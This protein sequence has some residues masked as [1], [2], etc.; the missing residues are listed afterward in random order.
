MAARNRPRALPKEDVDAHEEKDLWTRICSG[1]KELAAMSKRTQEIESELAHE[2]ER[3]GDGS[4]RVAPA[5]LPLV[6]PTR[7]LPI[8][9][10]SLFVVL[11]MFMNY[12]LFYV[13]VCY[14][15]LSLTRYLRLFLDRMETVR[16]PMERTEGAFRK[17]TKVGCA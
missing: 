8:I 5:S 13:I 6:I 17:G 16:N 12:R 9:V 3:L 2:Q 7:S 4:S 1:I 14:V 10:M 15:E 11:Y